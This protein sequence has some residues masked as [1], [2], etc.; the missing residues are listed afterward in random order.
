MATY[1]ALLAT[2]L[3]GN[4]YVPLSLTF[5]PRYNRQ[6]IERAD[7]VVLAVDKEGQRSLPALLERLE[8][9]LTILLPDSSVPRQF[10]EAFPQHTFLGED[11]LA[12]S[13]GLEARDGNENELAYILFTSGSTGVPKGVPVM[14]SSIVPLIESLL[15]RHQITSQDRIAQVNDLTFDLSVAEMFT[16]WFSGATLCPLQGSL[17]TNLTEFV[18]RC[19]INVLHAS[20]SVGLSAQKMGQL[21]PNSFSDLRITVFAGEALPIQLVKIWSEAAPNSLIDNL[22]GPTEAAVYVTGCTWRPDMPPAHL[23]NGTVPIGYPLPGVKIRIVDDELK[24]VTAGEKGEL[25]LG[26][27]QVASGYLADPDKTGSA[28]IRPVNC[29][30][31]YY[32][33]GDIVAR[34]DAGPLIFY[35]RKDHQIKILGM[36]VELGQ[37]EAALREATGVMDVAAIGWPPLKTSFAGVVAFIGKLEC[38][39]SS[40]RERLSKLLSRA[41]VPKDIYLMDRLPLTTSGKIDRNK[42]RSMLESNQLP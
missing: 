36:R 15:T 14:H 29:D 8:R 34:A 19:R 24:D 3:A 28:F 37:I 7:L 11:I 9:P 27:P 12:E 32:R 41:V 13:N 6:L 40:I 17:L 26:G 39:L 5:P 30:D 4:A 38:D 18:R 35:G 20:P 25:L 22:Y 23:Q 21:K 31:I 33:T 2:L 16:S 1:T 10:E 42:L